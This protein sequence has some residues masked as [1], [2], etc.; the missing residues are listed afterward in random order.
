MNLETWKVVLII[1]GEIFS[2][3]GCQEWRVSGEEIWT[4][5][6]GDDLNMAREDKAMHY[7]EKL[8]VKPESNQDKEKYL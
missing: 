8:E 5:R 2:L 4:Q 7:K 6:S 3:Q 1:F